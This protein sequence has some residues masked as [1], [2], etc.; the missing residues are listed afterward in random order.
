MKLEQFAAS[1]KAKVSA[2]GEPQQWFVNTKFGS[3]IMDSVHVWVA[4]TPKES[5]PN[6]IFHNADYVILMISEKNQRYETPDGVGPYKLEVSS[7]NKMPRLIGKT[8]SLDQIEAYLVKYFTN[9][10]KSLSLVEALLE[11]GPQPDPDAWYDK[12]GQLLHSACQ[13]GDLEK[14]SSALGHDPSEEENDCLSAAEL[15][16]DQGWAWDCVKN[17]F[18]EGHDEDAFSTIEVAKAL[19]VN[20]DGLEGI[21]DWSQAVEA[22]KPRILAA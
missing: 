2:I 6:N 4:T 17:Y 11:E 12:L 13:R 18:R 9:V 19:G 3:S 7:I 10:A 5:W 1:L 15:E 8:G 21:T 22:L 16:H 14:L 20:V